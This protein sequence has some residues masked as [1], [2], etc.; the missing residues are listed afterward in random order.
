MGYDLYVDGSL[1][2]LADH[3]PRPG[4]VW[5]RISDSRKVLSWRLSNSLDANFCVEAQIS[6]LVCPDDAN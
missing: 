3:L 2:A 6:H 4:S 1:D 5:N